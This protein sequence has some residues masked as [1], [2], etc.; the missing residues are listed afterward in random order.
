MLLFTQTTGAVTLFTQ[1]TFKSNYSLY[2]FPY[3]YTNWLFPSIWIASLFTYDVIRSAIRTRHSTSRPQNS[4]ILLFC[5]WLT[6]TPICNSGSV[7]IQRWKSPFQKPRGNMITVFIFIHFTSTAQTTQAN[8]LKRFPPWR[9]RCW[10]SV[11]LRN[12]GYR[13]AQR[14][15]P[16]LDGDPYPA[17]CRCWV[18]RARVAA[19]T[20]VR[21]TSVLPRPIQFNM[22][23]VFWYDN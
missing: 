10:N 16:T 17:T 11:A 3:Y 7:Q 21:H 9:R 2:L 18:S 6:G 20:C 19:G 4:T 14:K 22:T 8:I 1:T 12:R 23:I 13:R 5:Y 15:P